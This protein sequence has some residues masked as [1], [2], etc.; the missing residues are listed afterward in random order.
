MLELIRLKDL[1]RLSFLE[2]LLRDGDKECFVLDHHM[3]VLK[4]SAAATPRR[5]MVRKQDAKLARY[6]LREAGKLT[7]DVD[8]TA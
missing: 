4:G 7:R 1:V 3:S 8:V 2:V 5:L 6:V